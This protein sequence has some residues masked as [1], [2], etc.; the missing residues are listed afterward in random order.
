[1]YQTTPPPVPLYARFMYGMFDEREMIGIPRGFQEFFGAPESHG[2]TRYFTDAEMFDIDIIKGNKMLAALIQRGLPSNPIKGANDSTRGEQY[3][4]ITRMFPLIKEQGVIAGSQLLKRPAGEDP[5]NPRPRLERARLLARRA[6][7]EHQRRIIRR[8]EYLAAQSVLTGKM[9]ALHETT[10][11]DFIYDFLRDSDHTM[12]LALSWGA[13]GAKPLDD[14]DNACDRIIENNGGMPKAVLM[15]SSVTPLFIE[16]ESVQK[17]SDSNHFKLVD[18]ESIN[19][20]PPDIRR[21]VNA[22]MVVRGRIMTPKGRVLYILNYDEM[23]QEDDGTMKKFMPE[24]EVLVFASQA[25]CDRAFGPPELLPPQ[26]HQVQA[27]RE[28]FG[29][30]QSQP[31]QP[32]NSI[33][34]RHYQPG[35][36]YFDMLIPEN[37][38]NFQ[39]VAHSAPVFITTQTN[40]FCLLKG[41]A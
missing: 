36:I 33:D 14:L 39:P 34:S 3:Q 17:L 11:T 6:V 9:K 40:G 5:T 29:F 10:S 18:L 30:D 35:M 15:G 1:M 19:S 22:G 20:L 37:R 21:F 31:P 27:F 28:Y 16:N 12:N 24:D 41:A 2:E 4:T 8:F 25:R 7:Q 26:P 23:Y 13:A 32:P 38:E